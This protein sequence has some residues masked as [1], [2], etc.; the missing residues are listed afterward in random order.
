MSHARTWTQTLGSGYSV[1]LWVEEDD[2]GHPVRVDARAG[3]AGND[4]GNWLAA[5]CAAMSV[6]LRAGV[7]LSALTHGLRGR[8]GDPMSEAVS[9]ICQR[10]DETYLAAGQAEEK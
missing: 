4:M 9:W 5:L 1:T 7:P 6:N 8:G 3:K 2:E 10:L